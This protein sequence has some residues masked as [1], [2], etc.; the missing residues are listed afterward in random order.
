MFE[1]YLHDH[2]IISDPVKNLFQWEETKL[3]VLILSKSPLQI[4]WFPLC[5]WVFSFIVI[6]FP[7]DLKSIHNRGI[8][9]ARSLYLR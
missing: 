7:W 5:F 1:W 2:L 4:D 9:L 8:Y 3:I 6:H